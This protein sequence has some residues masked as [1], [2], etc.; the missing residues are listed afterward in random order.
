M[1]GCPGPPLP[2][3]QLA[4]FHPSHSPNIALL[5]DSQITTL[6]ES[7]FQHPSSFFH[8]FLSMLLLGWCSPYGVS[9]RRLRTP[10]YSFLPGLDTM[11]TTE[12][13]FTKPTLPE[14]FT[15]S[16]AGRWTCTLGAL[17]TGGQGVSQIVLYPALGDK[18]LTP[19][20]Y[21][22]PEQ[23]VTRPK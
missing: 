10:Q 13:M 14:L 12:Q 22:L 8:N 11:P 5:R 6:P 23:L 2:L 7:S 20:I 1:L 18:I 4:T 9:F 19:Q 15:F 3:V 16:T 21:Y 17:L